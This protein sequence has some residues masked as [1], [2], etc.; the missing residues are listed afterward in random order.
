MFV[1]GRERGRLAMEAYHRLGNPRERCV[2]NAQGSV[3]AGS[4][5]IAMLRVA[6]RTTK[7]G[8]CC[9]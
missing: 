3:A 7:L 8:L 4:R 6:A 5:Y 9:P 2:S 1:A